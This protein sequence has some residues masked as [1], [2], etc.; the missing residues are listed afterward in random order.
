MSGLVALILLWW[1][2]TLDREFFYRANHTIF[3]VYLVTSLLMIQWMLQC[4]NLKIHKNQLIQTLQYSFAIH[5]VRFVQLFKSSW[6]IHSHLWPYFTMNSEKFR[7]FHFRFK[8]QTFEISQH[9]ARNLTSEVNGRSK[10][11][12]CSCIT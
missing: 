2:C 10:V 5:Y 11:K 4:L 12:H 9:S 1:L 7:N 6:H 3:I 8:N